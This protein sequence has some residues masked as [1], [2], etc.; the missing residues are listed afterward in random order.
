MESIN[1]C[2]IDIRET[3]FSNILITGGNSIVPGFNE[4]LESGIHSRAPQ[5]VKTK[6]YSFLKSS[7]RQFGSWL[8]ASILASTGSFQNLW[9]SKKEYEEFGTSIITRKCPT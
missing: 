2:D 1:K 8:G 9:I 7:E 6:I 4:R 5:S 3:L